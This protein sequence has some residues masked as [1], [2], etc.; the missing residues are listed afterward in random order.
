[1]RFFKNLAKILTKPFGPIVMITNPRL[2]F[3][4]ILSGFLHPN[5]ILCGLTAV[6]ISYLLLEMLKIE[7]GHALKGSIFCNA[8]L[9]GLY[10]GTLY[11][12]DPI[13]LLLILLTMGLNIIICFTFDSVLTLLKLPILS[14]PFSVVAII[15]SLSTKKYTSLAHANYYFYELS[16]DFFNNLPAHIGVLFKSLG[17]FFCISDPAFGLLVL[18]SAFLYSPIIAVFLISGFYVGQSMDQFFTFTSNEFSHH[19]YYFNYSLIFTAIAG[20]FLTPSLHS[21]FWGGFAT[22]VTV[23]ISG[24]LA[25]L[26]SFASLPVM[27]LPFNL[28]AVLILKTIQAVTSN[29]MN[30][31]PTASPEES[32]EINRLLKLRH[33]VPEIGVFLPVSGNWTIQQGFDDSWTHTGKWQHALDFVIENNNKT[34]M[35]Q[36][37]E[38]SDYYSFGQTIFSPVSGYVIDCISHHNDN[39]IEE[40]DNLNNWGNYLIIKSN[41]GFFVKLAHLKKNSLKTQINAYV[42]AGQEIAECG[43]SGYSRE[44]HLHLQV[45]LS[46]IVGSSTVPFHLL[47]FYK[48]ESKKGFFHE[49]P[50]RGEAIAPFAFNFSLYRNLN[51]KLDEQIKFKRSDPSNKNQK[52]VVLTHKLDPKTG[53]TYWADG[54]SKLFYHML[55]SKFYFYDLKGDKHSPLWDLYAAAPTIPMILSQKISYIDYLPLKLTQ[56]RVKKIIL[57]F[58]HLLSGKSEFTKGQYEIDPETLTITGRT[59]VSGSQK[60]TYFKLDPIIG[61]TEFRVGENHYERI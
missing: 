11:L 44:P 48:T 5:I 37:L 9:L 52:E 42:E 24:A 45:Q 14:L 35:N 22:L 31:N 10:I 55:G 19:Y 33:K 25:S 46:P 3:F 8:I 59:Q 43:N 1:M 20:V 4:I 38:L 60:E 7:R 40:V 47:N 56:T 29:Q 6:I 32:I 2:G 61:I 53:R 16:P 57:S 39:K 17:T 54:E 26:F 49:T 51:F 23:L 50:K 18:S 36:G 30:Q 58:L 28:T 15:I 41:L 34:F 27:A 13:S 12:L 21:I